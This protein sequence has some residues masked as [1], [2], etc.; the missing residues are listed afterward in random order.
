MIGILQ[1]L[2]LREMGQESSELQ[3]AVMLQTYS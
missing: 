2:Q 3:A 1:Y